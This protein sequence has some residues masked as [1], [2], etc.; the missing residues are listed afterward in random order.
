MRQSLALRPRKRQVRARLAPY[1]SGELLV[2]RQCTHAASEPVTFLNERYPMNEVSR[3]IAAG[4]AP[5]DPAVSSVSDGSL[6][7]IARHELSR[8]RRWPRAFAR[9]R[10]DHRYYEIV[11]DTIRQGFDYRYFTIADGAGEVR[12]VQPFFICDQDLLA[13]L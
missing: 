1:R 5:A 12:A 3:H 9:L 8:C 2:A 7:V 6:R 10:K 11:E 4:A 13:G